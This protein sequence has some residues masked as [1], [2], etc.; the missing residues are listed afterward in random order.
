MGKKNPSSP[1]L[2]EYVWWWGLAGAR[3]G[4][5]SPSAAPGAAA[6]MGGMHCTFQL[7]AL[8]HAISY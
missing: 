8:L 2:L 6:T 5:G 4:S 3:R 7:L 1:V